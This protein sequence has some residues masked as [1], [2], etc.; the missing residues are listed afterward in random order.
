MLIRRLSLSNSRLPTKRRKRRREIDIRYLA[1]IHHCPL[2]SA[3][4]ASFPWFG[5]LGRSQECA[6]NHKECMKDKGESLPLLWKT[7]ITGGLKQPDK[8]EESS[9]RLPSPPLCFE[10]SP[11]KDNQ[12]KSVGPLRRWNQIDQPSN[13]LSVLERTGYLDAE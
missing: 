1:S 3:A 4:S 12:S 2:L 13:R 7:P 5:R 6:N 11:Q 9:F 10:K 8:C